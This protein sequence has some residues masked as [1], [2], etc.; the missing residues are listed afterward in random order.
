MNYNQ[1]LNQAKEVANN[2]YAPFSN[3]RVGACVLAE[4]GKYYCGCNVENSSYGLTVCAER[5]AIASA[6]ASGEKKIKAISV[7]SPDREM[8]FP[9][10]ACRQVIFEF[11]DK[12]IDIVTQYKDGYK[13]TTINK[14]MPEGFKL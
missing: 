13:V 1:L 6:V 9:C 12:E 5:N 11:Q 3:F 8:C 14:L 2:A 10:G 4:S 7:F